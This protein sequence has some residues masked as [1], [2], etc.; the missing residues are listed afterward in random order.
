MDW[1]VSM[2]FLVSVVFGDIV[3]IIT[4]DNNGPLHLSGDDNSLEDLSPDGNVAGEGTFLVNIFGFDGLFGGL[5]SKSDVLE[6]S[7]T[8]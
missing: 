7:D 6:V 1:D 5:E 4:P 8:R 2:S 3:E